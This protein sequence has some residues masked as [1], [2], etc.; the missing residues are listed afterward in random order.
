[1]AADN[2][3]RILGL[4]AVGELSEVDRIIE[5]L[6]ELIGDIESYDLDTLFGRVN[7]NTDNIETIN[8]DAETENS[9]YWKIAN[10]DF[11]VKAE[12]DSLTGN[13]KFTNNDGTVTLMQF[14][15]EPTMNSKRAVTSHGLYVTLKEHEVQVPVLPAATSTNVGRIYQYIGDTT[16][17][18]TNGKFYQNVLDS[19]S[20]TYSW[21]EK[22]VTSPLELSEDLFNSLV[23]RDG[24]LYS[25]SIQSNTLPVASVEYLGKIVQYTGLTTANYINGYFYKCIAE[26]ESGLTTYSWEAV[27]VQ[28]ST[29]I[30]DNDF[31]ALI[32]VADGLYVPASQVATMPVPDIAYTGKIVQY[33]GSTT[34]DYVQGDYYIGKYNATDGA[35]WEKLTYNKEEID[36]LISAAGH[37]EVVASLPTTDIKTN[38]IYLVPKLVAINGY[39]NGTANSDVYVSTGD[40]TTLTYDK[41]VYD[42]TAGYYV[43]NET[44]TGTNAETIKG[45]IDDGTYSK[46]SVNAA[47]KES[48]NIKT[49]YINLNGTTAGWEK[50]GDTEIDLS[51]YVKYEDLKEITLAEINQMWANAEGV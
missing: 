31:N 41:Y 28:N 46:I 34:T 39:Y 47:S 2:F 3:A 25:Y 48:Q 8:G 9:T 4:K 51:G 49:E 45:H 5:E 18:Y 20:G 26:T 15:T 10:T 19:T 40:D 50:I 29:H 13:W 6:K 11:V 44:I 36:E 23:F 12:Q 38:V 14:D 21:I 24:K 1:M 16:E 22:E 35:T 33:I 42:T 32:E 43:F 30:S 7:Q 27:E 37:F 17:N